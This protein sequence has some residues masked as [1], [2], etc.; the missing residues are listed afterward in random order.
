MVVFII[1]ARSDPVYEVEL[2]TTTKDDLAYLNQFVMHSSLDLVEAAMW[3]N[4][5]T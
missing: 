2:G 4:A 1:V 3:T 5:A